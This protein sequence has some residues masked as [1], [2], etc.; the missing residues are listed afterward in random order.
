MTLAIYAFGHGGGVPGPLEG[1][2]VVPAGNTNFALIPNFD[3]EWLDGRMSNVPGTPLW[4]S[5]EEA[6][7]HRMRELL[8][9]HPYWL[10]DCGPETALRIC[11]ALGSKPLT[12]NLQGILLTHLHSDHCGGVASVGYRTKY[13]EHHKP[14]LLYPEHLHSLALEVFREF[15]YVNL[16]ATER[17]LEAHFQVKQ[18]DKKGAVD[19][20]GFTLDWIP[21][22][23]N[24]F[25]ANKM[26]FP[27]CGY[28]VATPEGKVILFSGDTAAPIDTL[29]ARMLQDELVVHD[30]QFYNNGSQ[31][32][33]VHCPYG[34]LRHCVPAEKRGQVLLTHTSHALPEQAVQDGFRLLEGGSLIVL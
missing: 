25:L 13:Y 23:H 20:G 34:W 33:H 3:P 24:C 29:A 31:W 26:P 12:R 14:Q 22:D 32:D 15:E 11:G 28:R 10:I 17:G 30:V 5:T 4:F 2:Q 8:S 6:H 1:T 18:L 27:A 7:T 19:L 16:K 9:K 21:V